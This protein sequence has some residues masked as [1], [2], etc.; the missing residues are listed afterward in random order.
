MAAITTGRSDARRGERDQDESGI[1]QRVIAAARM[2]PVA[3][4]REVN[5]I[6]RRTAQDCPVG[7]G[8]TSTRAVLRASLRGD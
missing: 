2:L 1:Y 3:A 4:R 8:A 5:E 7:R 6:V